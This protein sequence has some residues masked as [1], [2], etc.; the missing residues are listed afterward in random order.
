MTADDRSEPDIA[1]LFAP[2]AVED[3]FVGV[4]IEAQDALGQLD[5][6]VDAELWASDLIGALA[7]SAAGPS[8]LMQ[9]LTGSLVPAAEAASTPGALAL[10]RAFAAVGSPDLRTAAAQAAARYTRATWPTP[11]GPGRS[12]LRRSVTAGTSPTPAAARSR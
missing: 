11:R 6:P 7:A 10:L 4:L 1:S 5:D 12:A 9:T 2:I 8:S 3:T